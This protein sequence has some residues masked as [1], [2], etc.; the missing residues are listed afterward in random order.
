M[1]GI[2]VVD[3][4]QHLSGPFCTW[5]LANLGADVIKVEAVGH[6]ESSRES[7]PFVNGRSIYFDSVNRGKRSIAIDLKTALGQETLHRLVAG[8]DVL[9]E[10]FRP[11]VLGRLGCS[12]EILKQINP[13]LIIA[14]VTGF[15]QDGP[16]SKRAAYDVVVQG[17]S[18]MISINGDVGTAG[19]RV[20]FSI[21][22]VAA[23]MFATIG[24]LDRLYERDARNKKARDLDISMLACQFACLE[25][26]FARHMNAGH[27]PRPNGSQHPSIT[28]F[29]LYQA[30]DGPMS[31]ATGNQKDWIT[32]CDAIGAAELADDARYATIEDRIANKRELELDI[33][34]ALC[35]HPR[36]Y[37]VEKL[38]GVGLAT[39]SVNTIEEAA[40]TL[41]EDTDSLSRI[42]HEGRDWAFVKN[43][44]RPADAPPEAPAPN[45]GEHTRAVLR[46]FGFGPKEIDDLYAAGAVG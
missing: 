39:G 40:A 38:V 15:G 6:G 16:F 46:D 29:G 27:S 18:G 22:D 41:L 24:I 1:N 7:G 2:R 33:N 31:I 10:N 3:L 43:P 34:R 45:V 37:W 44:L 42:S 26:A 20:G 32:L 28:P 36:E 30:K 21:G 13:R 8:A 25:N 19:T 4:T 14:H 5:T 23:A 12:D 17:M 9:V 35:A 11:G